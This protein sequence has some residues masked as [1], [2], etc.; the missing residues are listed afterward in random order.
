MLVVLLIGPGGKGG[1]GGRVCRKPAPHG[2]ARTSVPAG[3][4]VA[5][6]LKSIHPSSVL[7]SYSTQ[8]SFAPRSQASLRVQRR[9]YC[10]LFLLRLEATPHRWKRRHFLR[11]AIRV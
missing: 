10:L 9:R 5:V 1:Q 11:I 2:S 3:L 7:H 6:P 8:F 4:C